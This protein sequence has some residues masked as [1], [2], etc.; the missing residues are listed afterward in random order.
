MALATTVQPQ[1]PDA[2]AANSKKGAPVALVPFAEAAVQVQ[3]QIGYDETRTLG[4]TSQEL[5]TIEVPPSNGFLRHV[6]L[7][8]ELKGAATGVF[9]ADGPASVIQDVSLTDVN[10]S[11]VVT[12]TPGDELEILDVFGGYAPAGLNRDVTPAPTGT[13]NLVLR[14]PIEVSEDDGF[15]SL[16]NSS[17]SQ[18]Y[19]L[20]VTLAPASKVFSTVP[21]SPTVRIRASHESW[22]RPAAAD[23]MGRPA[24]Q[25]PPGSGSVMYHTRQ[26]FSA[27]SGPQRITV[28]R[29]GFYIRA[30]HLFFRDPATFMRTDTGIPTQWTLKH[31]D[32]VL[33]DVTDDLLKRRTRQLQP[34][35]HLATGHRVFAWNSER[36]GMLGHEGRANYLRT[37]R[38]DL[39]TIDG[40]FGAQTNVTVAVN[41][42][43]YVG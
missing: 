6:L 11:D 35:E 37:E 39:L 31:N 4:S 38:A 15:G 42:I 22:L 33:A 34:F 27:R 18:T 9:G 29:T 40:N 8:V 12:R 19:R 17:S 1:A 10:G 2:A 5:T 21:A 13:T 36:D 28:A 25:D 20:E 41:D 24:E 26:Q 30:I 7:S 16:A 14:V 32:V 43:A 23:A 3:R